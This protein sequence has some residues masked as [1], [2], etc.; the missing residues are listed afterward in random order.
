MLDFSSVP[1]RG[2]HDTLPGAEQR[3]RVDPGRR[4]ILPAHLLVGWRTRPAGGPG[5]QA[6]SWSRR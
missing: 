2:A 1:T 3:G 6:T 5:T 4:P